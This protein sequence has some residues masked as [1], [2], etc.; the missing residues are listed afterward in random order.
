MTEPVFLRKVGV[1][2]YGTL[3]A[4]VLHSTFDHLLQGFRIHVALHSLSQALGKG[5]G[6]EIARFIQAPALV[7]CWTQIQPLLRKSA[8]VGQHSSL[9]QRDP[10]ASL[11]P[12]CIV[13]FCLNYTLLLSFYLRLRLGARHLSSECFS[14]VLISFS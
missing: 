11:G 1:A 2:C 9:C 14:D 4:V 10:H 7:S 5:R 8:Q 13:F 12:L 3:I 6:E